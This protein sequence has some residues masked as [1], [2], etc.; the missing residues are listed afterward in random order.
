MEN[1]G[2]WEDALEKLEGISDET[3]MKIMRISYDGFCKN[4]K[5]ISLNSVR[6]F[7]GEDQDHVETR[8]I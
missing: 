4:E 5:K 7:N 1:E 3:T 2:K 8:N 6:F